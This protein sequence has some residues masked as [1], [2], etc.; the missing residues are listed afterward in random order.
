M[1]KCYAIAKQEDRMGGGSQGG[2]K[3]SH[4]GGKGC[5]EGKGGLAQSGLSLPRDAAKETR[6]VFSAQGVMEDVCKVFGE[7]GNKKERGLGKKT[8][9]AQ[10]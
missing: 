10:Q 6:H 8:G 5:Q 4:Q 9:K 7:G 3:R 1:G 2:G